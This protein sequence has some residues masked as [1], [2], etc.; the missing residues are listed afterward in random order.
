MK[1]VHQVTILWWI[2]FSGIF[3]REL[4]VV[5]FIWRITLGLLLIIRPWVIL[6]KLDYV[7]SKANLL[8]HENQYFSFPARIFQAH[9]SGSIFTQIWRFYRPSL[10][11]GICEYSLREWREKKR[12]RR[13]NWRKENCGK[14]AVARNEPKWKHFRERLSKHLRAYWH[15]RPSSRGE[16][17]FCK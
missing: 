6:I 13:R 7:H 10:G 3:L 14:F 17:Q 8:R 11:V 2:F 12:R 15:L 5:W 16:D 9:E 1:I 4:H